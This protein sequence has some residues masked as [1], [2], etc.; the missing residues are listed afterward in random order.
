MNKI[1]KVVKKNWDEISIAYAL[2]D[3]YA[4]GQNI[5]MDEH[6][7]IIEALRRSNGD[8]KDA[9]LTE[10][11]TYVSSL[12]EDQLLGLISN[13]KG[14]AHELHFVEVENSDGDSINA[15]V[16]EDTNHAKY[17]V[18]LQD[19]NG[20]I[21]S[22]QLKATDSEAYAQNAIDA[23]GSE[24]VVL[25]EELAEK[26]GVQTSGISNEQLTADVESVVDKLLKNTNLWGYLPYLSAW[27]IALISASLTKRY[28]KKEIEKTTYWRLMTVYCGA[29]ATKITII[30]AA[31]SIPGVNVVAGALLL[32]KVMFSTKKI[33][34]N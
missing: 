30:L 28:L 3:F 5:S 16:F 14:I 11:H 26:M 33:Y 17:D 2:G 4:N 8:L 31:L 29:K 32:M 23:V 7:Y 13:V 21:E 34:D 9:D 1:K 22:L 24:Q 6:G 10:L 19:E 12:D 18:V 20:P 27:S 25:T 15:Y